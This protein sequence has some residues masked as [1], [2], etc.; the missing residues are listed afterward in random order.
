M[1]CNHQVMNRV[2]AGAAVFLVSSAGSAVAQPGW[3]LSHQKISDTEGG[4]TGQLDNN[5]HFGTSASL[6]DLN[7][8]AGRRPHGECRTRNTVVQ[9]GVLRRVQKPLNGAAQR[10][11]E[12]T[13]GTIDRCQPAH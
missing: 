1:S 13:G 7:G 8:G 6:G 9:G 10:D 2:L 11:E 12:I 4:F 3:V 5:D